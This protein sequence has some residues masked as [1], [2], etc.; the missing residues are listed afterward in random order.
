MKINSPFQ[1]LPKECL[2]AASQGMVYAL[3]NDIILKVPFQYE[4]TEEDLE[5]AHCWDLSLRSLV[6][7]E[8]ESAVYQALQESPHPNFV[9][10]LIATRVDCLFL[11]RLETLQNAWPKA[12]HTQRYRW[13]LDLL[14]ALSW[15]E[16]IGF[17]H[18]DLAVR[19]LGVDRFSNCLKLFDFG[20]SISRSHPDYSN[21]MMRDHFGLATC[22]HF[23]LSGIDPFATVRSHSEAIEIRCKLE[24]GQWQVAKEAEVV[25]DTIQDGWAGRNGS[26]R[27]NQLFDRVANTFHRLS[28]YTTPTTLVEG[29][30]QKLQSRCQDWLRYAQA[31]PLWKDPDEYVA[32]CQHVGHQAVLD[33]WR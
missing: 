16:K 19:N 15:L 11:E 18:G 8:N 1:T 20:S 32:A 27:F 6:A 22:L 17:V 26:M 25:A 28:Q 30:Y 12:K 7:M 21:D 31:N 33:D 24:S 2:A 13:A 4:V 14:A 3:D 5:Q 10:R 29:H 9:R 23:I